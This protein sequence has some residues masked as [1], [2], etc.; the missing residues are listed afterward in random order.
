MSQTFSSMIQ[1]LVW[2]LK[3]FL[4]AEKEFWFNQILLFVNFSYV[5]C[6]LQQLCLLISSISSCLTSLAEAANA[7]QVLVDP[8][9]PDR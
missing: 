3:H 9:L 4:I 2:T 6:S 1:V 8:M 7:F 5:A